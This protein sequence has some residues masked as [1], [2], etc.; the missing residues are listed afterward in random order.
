[1]ENMNLPKMPKVSKPEFMKKKGKKKGKKG[2]K[3][4]GEEE[5][6]KKEDEGNDEKENEETEVAK[7]EGAE[8]ND[9]E[10][11]EE[12][13]E[14]VKIEDKDEGE[15]EKKPEDAEAEAVPEKKSSVLDS[16]KS[17]KTPKLPKMPTFGKKESTEEETKEED[18]EQGEKKPDEEG[19]TPE[20]EGKDKPEAEKKPSLAGSFKEKMPK[21][22]KMPKFGKKEDAEKAEELT[23]KKKEGQVDENKEV[24]GEGKKEGEAEEK[25]EGKEEETKEGEKGEVDEAVTEKK[26]SLMDSLKG[27]K[28]PKMPKMPKFSKSNKDESTGETEVAEEE[29]K[30]LEGEE[31]KDESDSNEKTEATTS[32]EE[33]AKEAGEEVPKEKVKAPGLLANLRNVASGLP[34]LFGKKEGTKEPDAE[35][36]ETDELLEKKEGD[37]VKMEEIKLDIGEDEKKDEADTKSQGSEKRDPEKGE[38]EKA[39]CSLPSRA[40]AGFFALDQQKRNG[41]IGV[42]VGLFLLLLIIIIAASMPG[43]WANRHRLVEGGKYV[44]TLTGCGMVRGHVDGKDRFHFRSLPYSVPVDRFAHSRLPASLEECG[45]EVQ[46]P[47]NSSV[48]C[49]RTTQDGTVGQEDCLTLDIATSSVV[50]SSPLPVVVYLPGDDDTLRPTS[51][52]AYSQGVVWVTVNVR[53]GVLGF[54]AHELLSGDEQPP[55][56]GN[57]GLGDLVTALKW[58]QLNIRHFGGDPGRVTMLGHRQGASL[59]TAL[60]AVRAGDGLYSRVWASGGAARLGE[61]SLEQ[62]TEQWGGVVK[63]VCGGRGRE[64]LVEVEAEELLAQAGAGEP[65]WAQDNLPSKGERSMAGLLVVDSKLLSRRV[66][67]VWAETPVTLP[68]VLGKEQERF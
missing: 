32:A 10:G 51:A 54:M 6:E 13:K 49:L 21:M 33:K 4:K 57:Y 19:E 17:I 34:A 52:L 8:K 20:E 25:K 59:A 41:L 23:D 58:V 28:A 42:A 31:K 66:P 9:E 22:P 36:G 29:K 5:T 35:A 43:G 55:T 62:A 45:E 50:Y 14:V 67:E 26:S 11:T 48:T 46:E 64:C 1:M 3:G 60:T 53:Q 18:V 44:E 27:M 56:S 24:D 30:L 2:K 39:P 63:A 40:M 61:L 38:A 65:Y 16:L 37:G 68:V 7:L 47:S 15:D 12:S